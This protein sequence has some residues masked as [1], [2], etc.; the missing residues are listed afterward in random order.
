MWKKVFE[1]GVKDRSHRVEV[2]AAAECD[3]AHVAIE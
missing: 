2:N 3:D 1:A